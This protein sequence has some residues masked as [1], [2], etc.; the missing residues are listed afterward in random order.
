MP[1]TSE[2]G[3]INVY[4]DQL[5]A[6]LNNEDNYARR[7]LRIPSDDWYKPKTGNLSTSTNRHRKRAKQW[8]KQEIEKY[9]EV[10]GDIN[11]KRVSQKLIQQL[12]IH[13]RKDK[14]LR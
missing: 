14:F 9:G 12:K 3:R 7:K 4:K 13:L 8:N 10:Y 5:N 6:Y 1:D 2:R 11:R